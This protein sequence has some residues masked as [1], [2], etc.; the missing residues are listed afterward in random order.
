MPNKIPALED[1]THISL[2]L[3]KAIHSINIWLRIY[4]LGNAYDLICNSINNSFLVYIM[5]IKETIWEVTEEN[6]IYQ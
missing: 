2:S 4:K 1:I 5:K 3:T 6:N